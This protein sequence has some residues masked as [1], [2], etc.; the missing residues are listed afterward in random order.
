MNYLAILFIISTLYYMINYV[1][2]NRKVDQKLLIYKNRIW[3]ILDSVYYLSTIG[4]LVW[5]IY[6]CFTPYKY[7]SA[8]MLLYTVIVSLIRWLGG[9]RVKYEM[10][11]SSIKIVLL[12]IMLIS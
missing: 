4:F 3:I 11:F 7:I 6:M 5:V 2:L 10:I 8:C 1:H 9:K 12:I